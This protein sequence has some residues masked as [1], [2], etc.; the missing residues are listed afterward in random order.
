M[1]SNAVPPL[2]TPEIGVSS[3]NSRVEGKVSDI[4]IK[5]PFI[6]EAKYTLEANPKGGDSRGR[7]AFVGDRSL[8]TLG[9]TY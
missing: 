6:E 3:Q 9:V 4:P 5:T 2:L 7:G 8:F 1:Y